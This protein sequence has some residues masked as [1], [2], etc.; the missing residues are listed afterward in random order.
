MNWSRSAADSGARSSSLAA[1]A[2]FSQ[3]FSSRAPSSVKGEIADGGEHH[4]AERGAARVVGA[5]SDAGEAHFVRS[6]G[7]DEVVVYGDGS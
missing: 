4:V 5:V 7:A 3:R 1:W 2:A 6:L